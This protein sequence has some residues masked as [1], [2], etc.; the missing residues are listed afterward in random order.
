M[1]E[2]LVNAPDPG[3]YMLCGTCRSPLNQKFRLVDG[4]VV[5]HDYIHPLQLHVDHEPTPIPADGP[6]SPVSVC[7][8]C[9]GGRS[10]SW[11]YPCAVFDV[12]ELTIRNPD[13]STEGYGSSDNW[14]ACVQC[15]DDI[16][17]GRFGMVLERALKKYPRDQRALV[18]PR[19]RK[20]HAG[21]REHRTGEAI[22][23]V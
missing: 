4:K 20:L 19:V 22:R 1:A 10:V 8:F 21:F 15:H 2:G 23:V 9:T 17:A 11:E 6:V 14:M 5:G 7:D 18:R 3:P 16:E 12:P 13:G